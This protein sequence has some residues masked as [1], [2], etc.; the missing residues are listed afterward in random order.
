VSNQFIR[1]SFVAY[2]AGLSGEKA[3]QHVVA[4]T[5]GPRFQPRGCKRATLLH[6]DQVAAVLGLDEKAIAA[7][8]VRY[9]ADHKLARA[10]IMAAN[11][12]SLRRVRS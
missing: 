8:T 3:R 1:A 10:P 7:A 6:L 12:K 5:F 9:L 2:L 11:T 4:G